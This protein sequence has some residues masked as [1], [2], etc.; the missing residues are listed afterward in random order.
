MQVFEEPTR[1]GALL[2]MVFINK[3]EL[4]MDVKI[5]GSLGCS[6]QEIVEFGILRGGNR[7]KNRNT[8]WDFRKA[9]FNLFRDLLGIISH[10]IHP[11]RERV[12]QDSW[13]IFKDHLL[14]AQERSILT[15]R[16]SS[17]NDRSS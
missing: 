8:A 16:I 6:D 12:V 10:V 17:K 4:V 9:D 14:K 3:E 15:S 13:M 5:K 2:D 7:A 11:W 1:K